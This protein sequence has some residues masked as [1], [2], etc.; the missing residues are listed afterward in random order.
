MAVFKLKDGFGFDETITPGKGALSKY[1]RNLPDWVVAPID[2]AQIASQDLTD[3]AVTRIQADLIFSQQISIGKP[4]VQLKVGAGGKLSIFVPG[5]DGDPLFHPDLFGDNIKVAATQRYVSLALTAE[6]NGSASASPGDL[7]F[8]F[9]GKSNVTFAYYNPFETGTKVRE[10]LKQTIEAFCIAGDLDD[11][12]N[13]PP[14]SIA[15]AEASG[16]LK[17][18]GSV[19]LL[20]VTNPLATADVP[21]AGAI[22]VTGGLSIPVEADYEFSGNYQVRVQRLASDGFRL[23]FYRKR[24]SEFDFS[25]S[26]SAALTIKLGDSDLF[27]KLMQAISSDPNGDLKDLE[28]AGLPASQSKAIQSA[29]KNAVNR[30]LEIGARLELSHLDESDAMFL[31]EVDLGKVQRDGRELL[32]SALEGDLSGLLAADQNIP[33]GIQVMKSL[34]STAK[35]FRHNLKINLLGIYNVLR[36]SKL[37]IHGT[38]TWDAST[39]ELVFTDQIAADKITIITSNFQVKN[40]DKLREILAGH[41]LITAAYRAG[42]NVVSGPDITGLQSFFSLEQNPGAIRIRNYFLIPVALG[43][44]TLHLTQTG[45]PESIDEFGKTTV[46]AEAGYDNAAFRSLFFAGSGLQDPLLYIA[47][48]R[49]AIQNLVTK[50]DT[51]DSRLLLATNDGFFHQ[52][53]KIGNVQSPQFAQACINAGVPEHMVHFVGTDYLDVVWFAETMQNAGEKLQAVDRY[54]AKNPAADPGN[55]EFLQLKKQLAE[56]LARAVEQA[57]T[58]FGG[59][60]GFEA[61]ALLGKSRTQKWLLVNQYVTC[62]LPAAKA[63]SPTDRRN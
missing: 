39:G 35:T 24:A 11:I 34:V 59:P 44:E 45:F 29:I 41:F 22:K 47:A 21:L 20:S 57:T 9:N 62:S 23:G 46:Y 2:L 56:A 25:A 28:A 17:F 36:L 58:D 3:P 12:I 50:G 1:F 13:M 38:T 48:G 53:Q 16:D 52:L 30:S 14:G 51:D 15:T 26:A 32:H 54:L 19:N 43:L 37:L 10:G 49:Q 31:Y 40:T 8:G 6:L 7:K 33:A 55:H 61:M 4:A 60:W 5:K 18:S 27:K 63:A 42:N